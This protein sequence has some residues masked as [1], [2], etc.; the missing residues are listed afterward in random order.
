MTLP[1]RLFA[2]ATALALP[3]MATGQEPR[4]FHRVATIEAVRML[5][6]DRD[7]GRRSIAEIVA[8][9][10]DGTLLVY[11]DGEQ[12][13]L[14]FVDIADPA[15]PRPAGFLAME[16]EPNSVVTLGGRA[17]AVVDT[18]PSKDAPSG[19]VA[20]VE[21]GSRRVEARCELGGQPDS[22]ALSPDGRFLV[23]VIENERDERRDQ[24]RIP[25]LPPAA[26]D[27]EPPP[28]AADDEAGGRAARTSSTRTT[29][30][31]PRRG[32]LPDGRP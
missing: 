14:G 2:L 26:V 15:A 16:G 28:N 22:V 31:P 32:R 5:P 27:Q 10:Q 17:F 11:V 19:H 8:A 12:R 3:T 29:G 4:V 7:R 25:Q 20:V 21:L 24:G 6:P 23:V 1:V 13:G 9:A 18:S 30:I